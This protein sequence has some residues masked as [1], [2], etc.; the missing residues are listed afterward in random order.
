MKSNELNL[1]SGGKKSRKMKSKHLRKTNKKYG[2]KPLKKM[3]KKI[4]KK[5]KTHKR[6]KNKTRKGGGSDNNLKNRTNNQ[7]KRTWGS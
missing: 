6:L 4:M 2:K 7:T 3:R 1:Q 5:T